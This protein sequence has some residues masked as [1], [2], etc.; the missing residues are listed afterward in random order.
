M[1]SG[2]KPPWK[3]RLHLYVEVP[4]YEDRNTTKNKIVTRHSSCE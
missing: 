2:K 3:P 4:K 1:K